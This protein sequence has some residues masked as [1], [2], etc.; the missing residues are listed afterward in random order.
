MNFGIR[1]GSGHWTRHP[2]ARHHA[3]PPV[4]DG[5]KFALTAFVALLRAVNVGGTSMLPMKELQ[6]MC[7][8]L[9]LEKVRTYIQSGNVVFESRMPERILRANLEQTLSKKMSKHVTVLIRTASELRTTLDANPFPTA[10]P[11][12]VGLV[13]LPEPAPSSLLTGLVVPGREEVRL[14]GRDIFIHYPDGMGRSKLKLPSETAN[15]TT[16]NLNTVAK[17]AAMA[18]A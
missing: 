6:A 11:A 8:E 10:K 4:G 2:S 18:G 13:F 3:R 17:L 16:R 7:V 1:P 15:G 12:Q 14:I 9:G 5:G